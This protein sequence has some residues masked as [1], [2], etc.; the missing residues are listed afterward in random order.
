MRRD[1]PLWQIHLYVGDLD[2]GVGHVMKIAI[3]QSN[4]DTGFLTQQTC[5]FS[6]HVPARADKMA[7]RDDNVGA[8]VSDRGRVKGMKVTTRVQIKRWARDKAAGRVGAVGS[9]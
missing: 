9:G 1:P 2:N 4:L 8:A 5:C 6:S 3:A 7:A